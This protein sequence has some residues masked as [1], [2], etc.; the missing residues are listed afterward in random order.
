MTE[1]SSIA[2]E[3]LIA[4]ATTAAGP[5]PTQNAN[6]YEKWLRSIDTIAVDL[7]FKYDQQSAVRTRI[8]E[9]QAAETFRG[10]VRAAKL[11][12]A[13]T[14]LVLLLETGTAK[15]GDSNSKAARLFGGIPAGHEVIRTDRTDS[16]LGR[17]MAERAHALVG[18]TVLVYRVQETLAGGSGHTVRV[19]KHLVDLGKDAGTSVSD[20]N[21]QV[22]PDAA[23]HNDESTPTGQAAPQP[24]AEGVPD[25]AFGE[26][27]TPAHDPMSVADARTTVWKAV[28]PKFDKDY[29][30]IVFHRV[31][32]HQELDD[33]GL[34]TN[35]D[36]LLGFAART[37]EPGTAAAE[38]IISEHNAALQPA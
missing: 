19:V 14:R 6:E 2:V 8:K 29:R 20:P 10:V 30:T 35:V 1:K 12:K 22:R 18:H 9:L 11:E 37:P 28:D 27:P 13:S 26:N 7:Y 4:Q 25:A 17:E 36:T 31:M 38:K 34:V 3:S 15:A 32:A 33:G 16:P 5:A 23:A 21:P 24:P